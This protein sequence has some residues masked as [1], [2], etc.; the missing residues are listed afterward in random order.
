VR[1]LDRFQGHSGLHLLAGCAADSVSYE[2]DQYGEGI[3]T[4]A[5]LQGMKGG[6]LDDGGMV[7]VTKL[8]DYAVKTVPQLATD[9]NGG[10]QQPDYEHTGVGTFDVG[11]ITRAA[12]ASIPLQTPLPMLL[13]PVLFDPEMNGDD[14][15]LTDPVRE[16]IEDRCTITSRDTNASAPAVYIDASSM[17]GALT[18]SGSYNVT[19]DIA[20]VKMSLFENSKRVANLPDVVGPIAS[21][22]QKQALAQRIATAVLAGAKNLGQ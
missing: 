13:R 21:D 9:A 15:S 3:L 14:Q 4:Y 18:P 16:A 7:D 20:T 10:I 2:A 8:F 17:A 5:L 6:A 22:D 12:A 1:A 19:H 11:Q